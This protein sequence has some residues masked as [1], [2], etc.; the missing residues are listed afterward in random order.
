MKKLK[1]I[2]LEGYA[3][4]RRPGQALPTLAEV[5]AEYLRN[6]AADKVK[7]KIAKL[8]KEIADLKHQYYSVTDLTPE[9]EMQLR[10]QMGEKGRELKRAKREE[11][12]GTAGYK[13][14]KPKRWQDS[15]GD[16]K[17]YEPGQD[18]SEGL[19]DFDDEDTP[20][21]ADRVIDL[22]DDKSASAIAEFAGSN[23]SLDMPTVVI[24]YHSIDDEAANEMVDTF[25]KFNSSHADSENWLI[26]HNNMPG[27]DDNILKALGFDLKITSSLMCIIFNPTNTDSVT[28]DQDLKLV[29]SAS[30]AYKLTP[31]N[32]CRKPGTTCS[33]Y[34]SSD[35]P[36]IEKYT[37]SNVVNESASFHERFVKYSDD[38]LR[39]MIVTLKRFDGTADDVRELEQEL[40]RRKH[41]KNKVNEY[42]DDETHSMGFNATGVET[43]DAAYDTPKDAMTEAFWT[44][45]NGNLR[46]NDWILEHYKNQLNETAILNDI[47][48]TKKSDSTI[49]VRNKK[50][51]KT[52]LYKIE[53][54]MATSFEPIN[55]IFDSKFDLTF[56]EIYSKPNLSIK[57]DLPVIKMINYT[58]DFDKMQTNKI[59][60]AFEKNQN[61]AIKWNM[62]RIM[63]TK[64]R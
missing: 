48:I 12:T 3:W 26:L 19:A 40:N 14:S 45:V 34:F 11:R 33:G 37:I 56:E 18:V 62:I 59:K 22:R 13:N 15:D 63:F 35:I 52:A 8:E 50:T 20:I 6:E 7:A 16:G 30:D 24:L 60:Q 43:Y 42:G 38:A 36:L 31:P 57:A 21:V 2:L 64:Q 1:D 27:S 39:D 17:W 55:K 23:L 28:V 54:T 44:R 58:I 47:I 61:I 51:N 9:R 32:I 53:Y 49:L 41:D 29:D 25:T 10:K 46:G 4:E 5:Q